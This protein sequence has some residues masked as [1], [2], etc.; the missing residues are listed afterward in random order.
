MRICLNLYTS[1]KTGR[2]L[3]KISSMKLEQKEAI[4]EETKEV[5]KWIAFDMEI[6]AFFVR[7]YS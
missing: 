3:Y 1:S 5:T 4:D 6:H 2:R 7:K